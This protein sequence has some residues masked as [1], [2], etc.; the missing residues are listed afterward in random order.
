MKCYC[1][2]ICLSGYSLFVFGMILPANTQKLLCRDQQISVKTLQLKGTFRAHRMACTAPRKHNPCGRFCSWFDFC[3]LLT[4]M[5]RIMA[6][7]ARVNKMR[8]HIMC[9]KQIG[10]GVFLDWIFQ[11]DGEKIHFCGDKDLKKHIEKQCGDEFESRGIWKSIPAFESDV[12]LRN[13]PG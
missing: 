5:S 3:T 13:S 7:V 11:W 8:F 10:K 12:H 2:L 4:C 6:W 1:N 9:Y